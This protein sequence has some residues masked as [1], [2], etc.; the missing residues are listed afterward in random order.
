MDGRTGRK[1]YDTSADRSLGRNRRVLAS[2]L[3]VFLLVVNVIG[4]GFLPVRPA[5]AGPAPFARDIVGDDIVVCTA[6]GMV[7]MDR[8]GHVVDTK[9]GG[10]HADLCVFC[11]P[12]MHVGAQTPAA[13]AV[14]VAIMPTE[15]PIA[16]F[17]PAEPSRPAPALLVGASSPRA[18]PLS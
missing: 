6:A 7:V 14:I 12:L 3:G 15:R 9:G 1:G 4:A 17:G 2:W 13:V 5:D 10:G 18:P 11:L 8:D 16:L